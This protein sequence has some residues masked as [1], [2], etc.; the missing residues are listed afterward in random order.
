MSRQV[1]I[2]TIVVLCGL[3][4]AG[5]T[6]KADEQA[7]AWYEEGKALREADEQVEA[8]QVFL[9]AAHSG[10]SNEMLLG[11]VWS[12]I[13]NMCRQANEHA[14]AYRVYGFS[15]EHFQASGDS[16]A[17]AYALNNMAWEQAALGQK[18]SALCL[19]AEAVRIYPRSPLTDKI[20]ETHTAAC[21]FAEEYDSV[22]LWSTPPASDYMLMVRAQAYS[23]LQEDD[24]ANYY[25]RLLLPRMTNPFY[26]DDI[27]YIL[28]HN[29]AKLGTDELRELSSERANVQRTIKTRHGKLAQAVQVLEQDL[30]RKAFPWWWSV[31]GLIA[32]LACGWSG[33]TLLVWRKRH[34]TRLLK[35]QQIREADDLRAALEWNDYEAFCRQ[36]DEH[37]K[38]LAGKLQVKG[39]NEQDVRMCVL[40]L[41]GLSHRE[42]ADMLNCS[43]KSVG[44]LKDI[45]A[46]KLGTS[47]GGLQGLC[48]Q[49][50][51]VRPS[52][53]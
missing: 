43:P 51:G 31:C 49:M 47:G 48:M 19:M 23:I 21:W 53:I 39:L 30:A 37:L 6:G 7:Q 46:R 16:L 2:W 40:V 4:M 29:D 11:R 52:F 12:N 26:L 27:Y 33:H 32:L 8:M 13:A 14:L 1:H 24:S 45:T 44:K 34:K 41:L 42:T 5:C 25:A 50:A 20:R 9:R 36:V 38:N 18:D 15:A 17:Y 28:T 3:V 22:L 35:L 10:T